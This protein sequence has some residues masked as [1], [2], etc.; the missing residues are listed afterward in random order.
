MRE[1]KVMIF[2]GD[3]AK[4]S[5]S[6]F[7]DVVQQDAFRRSNGSAVQQYQYTCAMQRD[8]VGTVFGDP[9]SV[10][11]DFSVCVMKTGQNL[12]Y[13]KLRG[14]RGGWIERQRASYHT[15]QTVSKSDDLYS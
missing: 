15:G 14:C 7:Q 4:L 9:E 8:R 5:E 11:F 2:R 13:E 3:I 6:N 10:T 12:F 1:I